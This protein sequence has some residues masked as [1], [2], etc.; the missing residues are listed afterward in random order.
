MK[1]EQ[2]ETKMR[3]TTIIS[4]SILTKIKLISYFTNSTISL[5]VEDSLNN[6]LLDFEKQNNIQIND[7]M[8][9]KDKFNND[10]SIIEEINDIEEEVKKNK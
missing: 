5:V 7:L 9:I 4:P 6:Y 3:F 10:E 2:N 1:N 8:R